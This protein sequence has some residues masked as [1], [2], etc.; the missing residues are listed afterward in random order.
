M[1]ST[2]LGA[3]LAALGGISM[4]TGPW[5]LKAL[6]KYRFEHWL[7]GAM[8]FALIILP[9]A[10]TFLA[11]PNAFD[12]MRHIPISALIRSNVFAFGWGIANVLCGLCLVRI[13]V[14]LTGGILGGLGLSL[15]VTVPMIFKGS[16]L[17][18]KAP[19]LNS[20]AGHSVMVGV[21][22]L[23][24]GVVLASVAGFGR[25]KVLKTQ[26]KTS[27]SFLVGLT[28]V[29]V[30]G[31]L[32]SFPNFSFAYSQGPIIENMTTVRANSNIK[33]TI[34]DKT[35]DCRVSR[36]GAVKLT[37]AGMVSLAGLSA[38]QAAAVT[39][40]A[41]KQGNGGVAPEVAI[42]TQEIF[43][44][45]PVW[46]LGMLAGAMVNILYPAFL[47]TKN[48]TWSIFV[49][50]WKETPIILACGVQSILAFVLMGKGSLVLGAL[51]ASVG[52]G[53]YQVGQM[54]GGQAVGF[55][56]GEWRGVHG[57]PRNLM[58]LA[59]L[60]IILASC[61]LSYSNTLAKS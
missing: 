32:S 42:D 38:K 21:A 61:I 48:G 14:A 29:I 33:M 7:F 41:L 15:G 30:A 6:R 43:A 1:N 57:R 58:Y 3:L 23:L 36:S 12:A 40:E 11:Y 28:M 51:G 22:F 2:F 20:P 24:C 18:S 26:Q 49:Q 35:Q 55:I 54:L 60:A 9:W 37:G 45:F 53:I 34:D 4:G 16:G 44:V 52:W 31:I 56:S 59:V 46:A 10:M 39:A 27:G 50:A 19:D 5:T 17:F 8:L 13:G 25:E 47:I